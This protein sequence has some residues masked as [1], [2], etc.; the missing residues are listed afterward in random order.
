MDQLTIFKIISPL[1]YLSSD[2]SALCQS[3]FKTSNRSPQMWDSAAAA[4]ILTNKHHSRKAIQKPLVLT[5]CRIHSLF[6]RLLIFLVIQ[7]GINLVQR[8]F[9]NIFLY[10]KKLLNLNKTQW[11]LIISGKLISVLYHIISVLHHNNNNRHLKLSS[12]FQPQGFVVLGFRFYDV[13]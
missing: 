12:M 8:M 7:N 10:L 11:Y 4:P 3:T 1:F 5:F 13:V 9:W 6:T 2:F